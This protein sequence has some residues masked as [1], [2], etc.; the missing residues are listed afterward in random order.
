MSYITRAY[1]NDN[2]TFLQHY[3]FF[4]AVTVVYLAWQASQR[5]V[6]HLDRNG[7][8]LKSGVI[9]FSCEFLLLDN[10]FFFVAVRGREGV[11]LL[12]FRIVLSET[13]FVTLIT[14][15]HQ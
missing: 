13:L 1:F 9:I 11:S 3:S 6:R 4:Q 2:I 14:K 7:Q 15:Y 12:Y 8:S 10:T 5:G